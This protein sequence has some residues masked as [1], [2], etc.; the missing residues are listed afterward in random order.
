M[1]TNIL[2][3]TKVDVLKDNELFEI[4]Y[5]KVSLQRKQKV[6][7]YRDSNDKY[8]SLATELLLKE[9]L[10]YFDINE[11]IEI[12]YDEKPKLKDLDIYF[13]FSHSNEYTICALSNEEIGSDIEYIKNDNLKIAERYFNT[14][15]YQNIINEND[16]DKRKELFYSY[17]TSLESFTKCIGQGLRIPFSEINVDLDNSIVNYKDTDYY[18]NQLKIDNKYKCT[19]CSKNKIDIEVISVD[20]KTILKK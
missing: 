2:L 8:L 18:I 13:N 9:G 4:A 19:T 3:I 1:K 5:N 16:I 14:Q 20:L 15:M 11:D 10:R 12:I 17:W 7:K 6:D